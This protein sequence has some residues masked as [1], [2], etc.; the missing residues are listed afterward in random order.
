MLFISF[1]LYYIFANNIIRIIAGKNSNINKNQKNLIINYYRKSLSSFFRIDDLILMDSSD[2]KIAYISS[3]TNEEAEIFLIASSEDTL[4]KK[5]FI[6]K[7]NQDFSFDSKIITFNSSMHNE[8]PSLTIVKI[9][10][11]EY[12][13]I[14]YNY[15]GHYEIINFDNEEMYDSQTNSRGLIST[16]QILKNTFFSLKYHNNSYILNAY[17][18]KIIS[19]LKLEKL[20]YSHQNIR[21]N[22]IDSSKENNDLEGSTKYPVSCF[23]IG[24]YI[25]CLYVNN[26]LLYTVSLFNIT[27]LNLI[28]NITLEEYTVKASGLFSKY[29]FIKKI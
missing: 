24:I 4:N 5:R 9:G 2:N 13:S 29:I 3:T 12:I 17:I 23:E 19:K 11:K 7:I 1:F 6:Y 28:L 25:E 26:E 20:Y 21:V 18:D 8:Y 14:Y 10:N 27:N 15:D 22:L 16:S